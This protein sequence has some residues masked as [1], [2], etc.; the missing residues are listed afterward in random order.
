MS[1]ISSPIKINF[2]T[3]DSFMK[4]NLYLKDKKAKN[5][6]LFFYI[7]ESGERIKISLGVTIPV[8]YWDS[9]RNEVKSSYPDYKLINDLIQNLTNKIKERFF[10]LKALYPDYLLK[11]LKEEYDKDLK[12]EKNKVGD[13]F[14]GLMNLFNLYIEYISE[15]KSKNTLKNIKAVKK[16]LIN[17]NKNYPL[18]ISKIDKYFVDVFLKYFI[19]NNLGNNY[20]FNVVKRIK[21]VLNWGLERNLHDSINFKQ[22]SFSNFIIGKDEIETFSL[23]IDEFRRIENLELDEEHLIH[24]RD[25]F[26]FACLTGQRYTDYKNNLHRDNIDGDFWNMK[27]DKT[28]SII[29]IPLNSKAVSILEK[30][31]YNLPIVSN[32]RTNTNLKIIGRLAKIDKPVTKIRKIGSKIVK[33][34]KPKF[35]FLSF[36]DS[37]RTFITISDEL[38]INPEIIRQIS[39]HKTYSE[40]KKYLHID[41]KR[42]TDESKKW[43][44]V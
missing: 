8:A 4:F 11:E 15:S 20:F 38:G 31:D 12:F 27:Q 43:E 39:G 33:T 3:G 30:Y 40:F 36:H 18:N 19:S 29:N 2:T 34:I 41:K 32:Q 10:E 25:V 14:N 1:P 28:N 44:N 22:I 6:L 23:S 24:I 5:T 42:L 26:V 17:F 35:E 16:H 7:S 21:T 9:K 37:R 13:S